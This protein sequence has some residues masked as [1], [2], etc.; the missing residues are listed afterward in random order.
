MTENI[1][2]VL[3]AMIGALIGALMSSIL[4]RAKFRHELRKQFRRDQFKL[5]EKFSSAVNKFIAAGTEKEGKKGVYDAVSAQAI[6]DSYESLRLCT[7]TRLLKRINVIQTKFGKTM[8]TVSD[9]D[10]EE[11]NSLLKDFVE[12]ARRDLGVR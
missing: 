12:E 9:K 6:L 8:S 10:V 7:S 4:Q 5:Y 3:A 1:A 2:T 11:M